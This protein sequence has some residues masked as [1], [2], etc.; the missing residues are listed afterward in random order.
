MSA[1]AFPAHESTRKRRRWGCTCGCVA[2][3]FLLVIVGTVMLYGILRPAPT[4]PKNAM[5]DSSVNGFGV[6][7]I[8]SNDQGE[9]EL[10]KFLF[11]RAERAQLEGLSE[12]DAKLMSGFLKVLRQFITSLV[13]TDCP[14]YLAYNPDARQESLLTVVPLRNKLSFVLLR[15]FLTSHYAQPQD[16]K[17]DSDI[18]PLGKVTSETSTSVMAVSQS[19]FVYSDDLPMLNRSLDYRSDPARDVEPEEKLQERLEE[20]TLDKPPAAEDIAL[21]I[22]NQPGRLENLIKLTENAMQTPGLGAKL[23]EALASNKM[24][25]DDV[26][27]LKFSGDLV[28]AD[29]A[30][31]EITFYFRQADHSA[32]FAAGA[33]LI[34]PQ[35]AGKREGSPF[36]IKQ[37]VRTRGTPVVVSLDISG[38]RIW[39][40]SI[41]PAP[42]PA[43]TPK[44]A[45]SSEALPQGPT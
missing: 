15:K 37:D 6:I 41:M 21:M 30:K 32:K 44:P 28:S 3:L 42:E 13:Q 25:Y 10:L 43:A 12:G 14:V 11:K 2:V 5:F 18:Y 34:L 38:I 36:E 19:E 9:S 7:R 39:L 40:E 20:L 4:Y 23:Q 27:A 35:F 24:S 29:R 26:Q 1:D 8:R 16:H 33:K 45:E 17:G 22:I 31:V